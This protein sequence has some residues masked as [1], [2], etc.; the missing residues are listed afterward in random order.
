MEVQNIPYSA[1]EAQVRK[2]WLDNYEVAIFVWLCHA[3]I[4]CW[5]FISKI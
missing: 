2:Q 3:I 4:S 1:I 5:L